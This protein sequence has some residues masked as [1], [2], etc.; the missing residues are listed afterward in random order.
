MMILATEIHSALPDTYIPGGMDMPI[1]N[2]KD[3]SGLL[4]I[5]ELFEVDTPE[6]RRTMLKAVTAIDRVLVRD[7][8]KKATDRAKKRPSK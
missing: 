7:A 6:E 4:N 3:L 1:Y 8:V 2:G 5:L